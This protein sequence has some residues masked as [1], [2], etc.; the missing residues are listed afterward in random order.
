MTQS[1]ISPVHNLVRCLSKSNLKVISNGNLPYPNHDLP[2]HLVC[3]SP[4]VIMFYCLSICIAPNIYPISSSSARYHNSL[5]CVPIVV[6]FKS[7]GNLHLDHDSFVKVN[8]ISHSYCQ[9]MHLEQ[10]LEGKMSNENPFYDKHNFC[11][12]FAPP[13]GMLH[14]SG[15]QIPP[16]HLYSGYQPPFMQSQLSQQGIAQLWSSHCLYSCQ[17][18]T[19]NNQNLP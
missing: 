9:C 6:S 8:F 18:R 5:S 1:I 12:G 3:C 19:S 16:P 4:V 14:A 17:L 15:Y 13:S 2:H 10:Q 11:A 7:K